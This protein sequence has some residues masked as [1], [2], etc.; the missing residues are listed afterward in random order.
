MNRLART[1]NIRRWSYLAALSLTLLCLQVPIFASTIGL[2]QY[3]AGATYASSIALGYPFKLTV[4]QIAYFEQ[5]DLNFRV[6]N[7]TEDSR[8]PSDVQCVWAGQVSILV[9]AI[10]ASNGDVVGDFTVTIVGGGGPALDDSST[11][12]VEGYVVKLASVEP[13]PVSTRTIQLSEYIATLIVFKAESNDSES[14]IA[15]N[16]VAVDAAGIIL[17]KLDV[18][19]EVSLSIAVYNNLNEDKPFVAILEARSMDDGVTRFLVA[20]E[21]TVSANSRIDLGMPWTPDDAG[22]YQL[23][24][25]LIDSFDQPQILSPVMTSEIIVQAGMNGDGETIVTLMEGEREGPL[26][27]QRIY[28]DRVEGLNFPE[29]PIAMDEGLPITLRIGE[30]ASNG[31]TVVLTLTKIQDGRA[32]FL[33][34]VDENRPCPICWYQLELLSGWP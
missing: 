32:T 34:T 12:S 13:Y 9:E 2:A 33:K 5:A 6:V 14:I 29:Y 16:P 23:R 30:K 17:E 11:A 18:G 28:P 19:H 4:N 21:G 27:V 24:T 10:R 1:S 22:V 20:P 15:S 8:C 26:L 25:F 7:V 3:A 31:C